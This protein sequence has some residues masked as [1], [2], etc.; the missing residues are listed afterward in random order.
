MRDPKDEAVEDSVRDARKKARLSARALAAPEAIEAF[1]ET[2]ASWRWITV[3]DVAETR[4]GKMLDKEKNSGEAQPYLRNKAL[5][6]VSFPL[7]PSPNTGG[8]WPKWIN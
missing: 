8:S 7:A 4:L 5:A 6:R 3:S 1:F 2:P